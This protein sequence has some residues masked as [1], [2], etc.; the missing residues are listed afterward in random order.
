[1]ASAHCVMRHCHLV[2]RRRTGTM[3]IKDE[4][5]GRVGFLCVA[6]L[7]SLIGHLLGHQ[8]VDLSAILRHGQHEEG[9]VVWR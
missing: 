6:G 4:Q 7:L 5:A 3:R 9:L 1:M 2:G 8:L